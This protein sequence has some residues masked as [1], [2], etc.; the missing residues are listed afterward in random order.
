MLTRCLTFPAIMQ[1]MVCS[2]NREDALSV[3]MSG[4]KIPLVYP[5]RNNHNL[6]HIILPKYIL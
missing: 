5:Y 3:K 2:F 4:N 1:D 6:L